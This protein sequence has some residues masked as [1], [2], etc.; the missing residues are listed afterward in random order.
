MSTLR[1]RI[2]NKTI[3]VDHLHLR[4]EEKSHITT[5]AALN[6]NGVELNTDKYFTLST[7]W[8]N[9]CS[10]DGRV[11]FRD[12]DD[13]NYSLKWDASDTEDPTNIGD[14]I[15]VF[16]SVAGGAGMIVPVDCTLVRVAHSWTESGNVNCDQ[17]MITLTSTPPT[18]TTGTW[19]MTL[20]HDWEINDAAMGTGSVAR[21]SF[22][23]A[24]DVTP[25][26]SLS[27]GDHVILAFY[28][29]DVFSGSPT[30]HGTTTYYFK[31]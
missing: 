10:L 21:H 12:T 16:N 7:Y 1:E 18:G 29:N 25:A 13:T 5:S 2:D 26:V 11:Y 19:T 23:L 6:I 8:Y 31:T 17:H 9:C 4:G 28:S 3:E 24:E 14:E 15:S 20:R 30:C 22:T 27:A